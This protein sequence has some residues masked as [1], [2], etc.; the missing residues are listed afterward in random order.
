MKLRNVRCLSFHLA[1][2]DQFHFALFAQMANRT[3]TTLH[4]RQDCPDLKPLYI[5]FSDMP[6]VSISNDQRRLIAEANF[7][8]TVHNG[9]PTNLHTPIY[10]PRGGYVAFLGR[11]WR[12][13]R[14]AICLADDR[15]NLL[16]RKSRLAHCSLRIGSQSL[17]LS[18]VRKS[19][20]RS[21]ATNERTATRLQPR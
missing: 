17:N 21:P 6:L 10:N 13:K 16:F 14:F 20:G 9:I 7:V 19:E 4:G 3:L 8:G 2:I 5:S 1:P 18:L 11:I 15:D 12:E